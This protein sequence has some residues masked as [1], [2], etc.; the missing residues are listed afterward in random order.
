M[1]EAAGRF[2]EA[3]GRFKGGCSRGSSSGGSAAASRLRRAL[4]REDLGAAA[5]ELGAAFAAFELLGAAEDLGAAFAAFEL[6][7]ADAFAFTP[8]NVFAFASHIQ[9]W[10]RTVGTKLH[11][12]E[13]DKKWHPSLW[14]WLRVGI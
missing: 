13:H 7:E 1:P 12:R 5:E 3:A 10:P 9:K 8:G 14:S 2:K 6:L 4:G 11:L